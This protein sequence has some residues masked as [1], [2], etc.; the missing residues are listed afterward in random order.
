MGVTS[1]ARSAPR[2]APSTQV[3]PNDEV[4]FVLA[5]ETLSSRCERKKDARIC[6]GGKLRFT[7]C[8]RA[9]IRACA[10]PGQETLGCNRLR[11]RGAVMR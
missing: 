5:C 1:C 9:Q 3:V 2:S 6:L 10:D 4:E 11:D 7:G 8:K